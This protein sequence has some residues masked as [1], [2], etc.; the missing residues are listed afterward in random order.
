M[1]AVIL[2]EEH[3]MRP[4]PN[5]WAHISPP[6]LPPAL[7]RIVQPEYVR[8][9][10]KAVEQF[11][12]R[13][14]DPGL[15]PR[16]ACGLLEGAPLDA[17]FMPGRRNRVKHTDIVAALRESLGELHYRAFR[18]PHRLGAQRFARERHAEM[19]KIYDGH[20]APFAID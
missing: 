3:K 20:V 15:A 19:Q 17:K 8:T 5:K 11:G 6:D 2:A 13:Y 4:R 18:S 12:V 1:R 10:A 16:V 7:Q 14:R 9:E